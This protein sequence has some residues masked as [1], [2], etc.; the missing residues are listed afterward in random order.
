MSWYYLDIKGVTRGPVPSTF[1]LQNYHYKTGK[2]VLL[3]TGIR[4]ENN[5]HK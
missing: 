3:S 4:D 5:R 2:I 1:I